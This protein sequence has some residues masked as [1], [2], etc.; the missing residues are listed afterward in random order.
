VSLLRGQS[1]AAALV[2]P[3]I[4]HGKLPSADGAAAL[5]AALVVD[6]VARE[7][8]QNRGKDCAPL[9][10][11]GLPDGGGGGPPRE[12]FRAILEAIESLRMPAVASG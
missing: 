8:D 7:T 6:D 1:G 9:S 5:G 10:A 3:C 4:Q 2:R 11:G 12:L